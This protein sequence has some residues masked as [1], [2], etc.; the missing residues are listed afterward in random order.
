MRDGFFKTTSQPTGII[1]VIWRRVAQPR[2]P[3]GTRKARL[4]PPFTYRIVPPSP[5]LI[6]R[7]KAAQ[8]GWLVYPFR[9]HLRHLCRQPADPVD[10]G[11]KTGGRADGDG[12]RWRWLVKKYSR[13]LHVRTSRYEWRGSEA[14]AAN[15][16]RDW[17]AGDPGKRCYGCSDKLDVAELMKA[18]GRRSKTFPKNNEEVDVKSWLF[19]PLCFRPQLLPAQLFPPDTGG[20]PPS[21]SPTSTP[22]THP[23]KRTLHNPRLHI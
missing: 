20:A 16:G 9:I 1:R 14:A 18:W 21:A 23:T 15:A 4:Y 10:W 17:G 13:M 3:H 19:F 7:T 11:V 2:P 8:A 12:H 22:D 6:R 5:P